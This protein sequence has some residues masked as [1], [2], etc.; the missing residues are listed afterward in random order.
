LF[1]DAEARRDLG[2]G[3]TS[4][5]TARRGWTAFANGKLATDAFALDLTK[6]GIMSSS[7]SLGFRIAQPLR[8][9]RGG[10]AMMIPTSWDYVTQSATDTPSRMSLSPSGREIDA[11]LS[12]GAPLLNRT[13]WLG[14]NL[15]VRRQPGHIANASNDMGAALRL[16]L[17]F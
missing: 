14:G 10:F 7:D 11:E 6:I 16:S 4:T 5:L 1:L 8:V 9:E 3:W 2:S 17:G 13:A 15:Y 12:Y